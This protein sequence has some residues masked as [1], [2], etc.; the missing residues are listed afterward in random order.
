MSYFIIR[1]LYVKYLILN[2]LPFATISILSFLYGHNK[3][4][5]IFTINLGVNPPQI[6]KI[7]ILKKIIA[8]DPPHLKTSLL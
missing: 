7:Y 4:H 2:E 3:T 5:D 8:N 6:K 1:S